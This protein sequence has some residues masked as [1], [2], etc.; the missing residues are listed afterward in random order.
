MKKCQVRSLCVTNVSLLM[1]RDCGTVQSP[2]VLAEAV[3]H[4]TCNREVH[5]SNHDR[6][7]TIVT[8]GFRGFPQSV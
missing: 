8:E 3:T 7:L 2:S 6:T 5:G 1:T 4:V